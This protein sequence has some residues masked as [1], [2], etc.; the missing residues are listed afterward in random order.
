[1]RRILGIAGVVTLV[2]LS[3]CSA[4][5]SDGTPIDS[6][7]T[8]SAA[9][10]TTAADAAGQVKFGTMDSP[11]G[12]GTAT[13]DPT[14]NGGPTLKVVSATD[15]GFT[16]TPG[17]DIELEDS[18]KGFIGWCN[19]QGGIQGVPLELVIVDAALFQVPAAI[20]KI[21]ASAFAMVGGGLVFD[22]QEFPRFH[23]CKM[24][25]FAAYTVTSAKAGSN[26]K[27]QPIPNPA[28][29]KPTSWLLYLKK[30][31][32]QDIKK[33][34]ILTGNFETTLNVAKSLKE[35][36]EIVGGF[37]SI[38]IIEYNS[39][40]EASWTPFAQ[41]LKD[42][43]ITAM[44]FVGS[45]S[46]IIPLLKAMQEIGYKPNVIFNEANFYDSSIENLGPMSDGLIARTVYSPFEESENFPA[47]SDYLSIMKKH[48][49]SGKIAGLGLQTFSAYLMFA[50]SVNECLKTNNGVIERECVLAQAK[51]ITSWNAGGLHTETNPSGD[52]PPKCGTLMQLQG[53][54]WTRLFP[55]LGSA[56][57]NGN[58]WHCDE[59][60]VANL[61][62]VYGDAAP[63]I[64]KSRPN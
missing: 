2:A 25:D 18:A 42:K 52:T 56:D 36:M 11:C 51:K 45:P 23:E 3:A 1:M 22:N 10:E 34:A 30:N 55:V 58:G 5:G 9:V 40:G 27:I 46:N 35:T 43:A 7:P 24:I 19:E 54:K 28:Q 41:K 14:Q 33:T 8:D 21:C 39:A 47:M 4:S 32:V 12:K 6:A 31:H 63:G 29:V 16:I 57:D 15:K 49:P 20:E 50:Q 61:T 64:D 53:G 13:V 59:D 37:D 44:S 62:G 48:N 60:G 17:L 38:D 26:G